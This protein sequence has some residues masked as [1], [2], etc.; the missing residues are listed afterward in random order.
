M[1]DTYNITGQVGAV[2][3]EAK[4]EKNTFQQ[5][6]LNSSSDLSKLAEELTL[7]LAGMK[8][9]PDAIDHFEELTV[10]KQAQEAAQ[11]QDK[12]KLLEHL[13]SAGQWTFKVAT[14]IGV[15]LAAEVIKKTMGM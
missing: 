1:G 13:K 14:D 3:R 5:V 10:V 7:L 8:N 9:Q 11:Q 15:N 4:S 6:S 12:P 2:G